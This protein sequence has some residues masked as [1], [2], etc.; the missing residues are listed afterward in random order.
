M[1]LSDNLKK[2]RKDNNLSQEQLAERLGVSRQ[3]V[4]KWESGQ[5]YPEMDK[6]IQLAKMF[7]LNMDELINQDIRELNTEKQAKLNIN[8]YIDDFLNFFSKTIDMFSSMKFKQKCKC[9]LEQFMIAI[10]LLILFLIIG[11]IGSSIVSGLLSALPTFIYSIIFRIIESIYLIVAVTLGVILL[12]HIFKT[13]YLDYYVIVSE[14]KDLQEDIIEN[15]QENTES[16]N[17][18]NKIYLEKKQEKIVIRDPKHSEYSF[19]SG[20]LKIILFFIKMF[21]ALI[22]SGFCISLIG[23]TLSL[24]VSFLIIKS[25]IFFFGTFLTLLACIVINIIILI[26]LLNFIINRKNKK[27]LLLYSFLTSLLLCGI[28]VGMII[29]GISE[30]N[31]IDDVNNNA[32][33]ESEIL[34]PMN[35]NLIINNFFNVDEIE[36]I[37]DERDDIKIS[38][39][40]TK[41][42]ELD[43]Y[44]QSDNIVYFH[45]ELANN[46]VFEI[47]RANIDAINNKKIIDYSK[48]KVYIYASKDTI[49]KLKTNY[50]NYIKN[51][52][53]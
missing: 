43:Y 46:N 28:G 42:Y 18:N 7:N 10:I 14:K 33:L 38:Y 8:K 3:A 48:T 26:I 31:Y 27:R 39:K 49:N 32:Y 44:Y 15:N 2:I 24:I 29:I 13:R 9:L 16:K 25:G 12:I 11:S 52:N 47:T 1:N 35:K 21:T 37:E 4:S 19:I 5:A 36:W 20:F 40:H 17:N 45:F 30:F 53:Y 41:Y 50:D 6:V 51:A 23:F 34:I 22:A